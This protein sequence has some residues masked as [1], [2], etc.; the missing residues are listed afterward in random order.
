MIQDFTNTFD[1]KQIVKVKAARVRGNRMLK[2]IVGI[3]LTSTM[4][5]GL[6]ASVVFGFLIRSGLNELA[7]KQISKLELIKGQ[8]GLYQQKNELLNQVKI[9]KI[10]SNMGLYDPTSR[11]IRRL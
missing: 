5:A 11:Q 7:D 3:L 10:A 9:E 8:Q 4:I 2:K 6:S 1:G